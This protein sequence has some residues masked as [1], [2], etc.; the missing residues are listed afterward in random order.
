MAHHSRKSSKSDEKVC[1]INPRTGRRRCETKSAT[2][3]KKKKGS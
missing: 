1:K 3:R 2:K